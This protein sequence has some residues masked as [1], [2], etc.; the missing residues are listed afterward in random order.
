[1]CSKSKGKTNFHYFL[2]HVVPLFYGIAVN[3]V[4][5]PPPRCPNVVVHFE[6]TNSRRTL[7]LHSLSEKGRAKSFLKVSYFLVNRK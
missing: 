7:E 4:S 6:K 5:T 2:P 1:M 3:K